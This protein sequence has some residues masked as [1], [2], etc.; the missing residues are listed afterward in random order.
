MSF[1]KDL[2][3]LINCNSLEEGSNT[4]DF[5]LADYLADCLEAFDRAVQRREE[6]KE[7]AQ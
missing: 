7:P 1:R 4:P 6:W 3:H 2:E 5:I